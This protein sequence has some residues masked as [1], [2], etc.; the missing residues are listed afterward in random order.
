MGTLEYKGRIEF[1]FEILAF[2]QYGERRVDFVVSLEDVKI[3]PQLDHELGF[4]TV[5]IGG[6]KD[7]MNISCTG[8]TSR[9]DAIAGW[10]NRPLFNPI[11]ATSVGNSGTAPYSTVDMTAVTTITV[12]Y[13]DGLTVPFTEPIAATRARFDS[14]GGP[15]GS[16]PQHGSV[17]RDYA[18]TLQLDR[19]P[20]SDHR[21]EAIHVDDALSNTNRTFPSF[22]GKA[23]PGA[24]GGGR[25]LHRLMGTRP[26]ANRLEARKVC[27]DVWGANYA[28]GG[29]QCD[30][31]P[32]AVTYE[33]AA[34]S[35]AGIGCGDSSEPVNANW[36]NWH[37]SA[38]PIDGNHN[39]RGG[40]LLSALF[41]TNR[42]LDCDEFYVNIVR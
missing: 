18:P 2:A 26:D 17:F 20:G 31:Y 5:N 23:P 28:T 13:R 25:P 34:M 11:I 41:R 33:G 39:S 22:A 15:I 14:A 12:E 38:R 6:C 4:I 30:E 24:V 10:Y 40:S 36:R 16:A 21:Q 9:T 35:T 42:V 29:L 27:L 7:V 37:G 32:F 1:V 19:R 3:S 8:E